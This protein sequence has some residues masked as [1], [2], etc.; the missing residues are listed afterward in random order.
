MADYGLGRR[1]AADPRDGRHP[2]AA[3]L[4]VVAPVLRSYRYWR[5]GPVLDQGSAPQC[6]GFAWRQWLSSAPLMTAG[7]PAASAIY[8][9]AQL[10]DEWPGEAYDGT[11]VR[12]G[13]KV[14]QA[15]GRVGEYVWAGTVAEVKAWVLTRGPVVMGTD[16]YDGMFEPDVKGYVWP[17]GAVAGGHAYIVV[18]FRTDDPS[19]GKGS[20]RCLNSWGTGW[21]QSGRFWLYEDSLKML[22]GQAGEACAAVEVRP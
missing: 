22:L 1:P 2:M 12:A 13:A 8:S 7:G 15:E 16:W 10:V 3:A 5:T 4:G 21:G 17:G 14:L 11:S 20:F 6:V 9:A 19:V 18:G